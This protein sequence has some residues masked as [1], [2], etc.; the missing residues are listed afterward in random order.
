MFKAMIPLIHVYLPSFLTRYSL[1][2]MTVALPWV[3]QMR[4]EH[5]N[6]I[7]GSFIVFFSGSLLAAFWISKK[8]KSLDIPV[9]LVQMIILQAALSALCFW[10]TTPWLLYLI[11]FIQ[12]FSLGAL[13]PVNQIWVNEH[14]NELCRIALTKRSTF[15][16]VMVSAGILAGSALGSVVQNYVSTAEVAMAYGIV[17]CLLPG[18]GAAIYL[19][20]SSKKT[21]EEKKLPQ[22]KPATWNELWVWLQSHPASMSAIIFYILSLTVFKIWIIAIPF[23]IRENPSFLNLESATS[24]LGVLFMFHSISFLISQYVLSKTSDRLSNNPKTNSMWVGILTL[25]QGLFVWFGFLSGSAVITLSCI[26]IGGGILA[27]IIHPVLMNSLYIEIPERQGILMRKVLIVLSVSADIG[28][29]F[30]CGLLLFPIPI[31]GG[32]PLMIIPLILICVFMFYLNT[33]KGLKNAYQ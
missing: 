30:A 25:M 9:V 18:I 10:I 23:S 21:S 12:G 20:K 6:A 11:R 26:V 8:I 4:G 31:H 32:L 3:L 13:R 28:Q 17:A 19:N 33:Y 15:S 27:G 16:Q 24:F 7:A 1:Q 14:Q 22:L 29:I 5:L 2:L